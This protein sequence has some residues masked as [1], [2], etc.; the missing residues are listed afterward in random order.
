MGCSAGSLGAF[1]N[2]PF[3]FKRFPQSVHRVWG[4]SEVG[5]VSASQWYRAPKPF[6]KVLRS[7]QQHRHGGPFYNSNSNSYANLTG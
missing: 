1:I 3:V 5:I 4:D 2:A 7:P 6:V